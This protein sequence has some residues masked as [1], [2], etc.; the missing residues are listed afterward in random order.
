MRTLFAFFAVIVV[1]TWLA[2]CEW[3]DHRKIVKAGGYLEGAE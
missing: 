3:N 2:V 1:G